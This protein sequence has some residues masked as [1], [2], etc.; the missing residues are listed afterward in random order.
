MQLLPSIN[1]QTQGT[2]VGA[3]TTSL[4]LRGLS[5]NETLVM[6]DGI[7][8]HPTSNTQTDAGLFRG[9]TPTDVDL[10]PAS[11]IDHVEVL[12][13]GASAQYGSDAVA[14][15]I[16]ILLKTSDHGGSIQSDT[17]QYHAGDGLT[18]NLSLD[19]GFKL[20]DRGFIHA[21]L[22]YTYHARTDRTGVD[23]R[24]GVQDSHWLGDP[25]SNRVSLAVNAGYHVTDQIDAYA[26]VT[27]AH[28]DAQDFQIYRLPSIL[29][30]IYPAGFS[31]SLLISENDYAYTGGVRGE[32]FHGWS[33]DLN[34]TY[35][36]DGS[37]INMQHSANTS[38]FAATGS[39]PT[40]F[41]LSS[42]A[43]SQWS[44]NASIKRGFDT[45]LFAAPVNVDLGVEYRRE[46]YAQGAGDYGSYI[47]G[48]S[49]A[50]P[51]VL[52]TSAV[53]VTRN[54]EAVY[55]D[56]STKLTD[57]WQA[58]IAGRYENYSDFGS[59]GT[60]KFSTRYDFTDKIAVRATVNNSI[61]APT[62]PEE[63]HT[64]M[65]V[66]TSGAT[67]ELAPNSA[68]AKVLGATPLKPENS[69]NYTAGLVLRPT[70][71]WSF[72]ADFYQI[73]IDNRIL[74][75]G[76]YSGAQA[77]AAYAAAGR[78][79]PI[80]TSASA[81]S[82]S[83]LTNAANTRTQGLD[84]NTSYRLG[85]GDWG[86]LVLDASVNF[87]QTNIL[88]IGTNAL[89]RTLLN[90]QQIGYLTTDDPQN[91]WIVGGTWNVNRFTVNIHEQGYGRL[92]D[93]MTYQTGPNAFSSSV[94]QTYYMRAASLTNASLTYHATDRL[95]LTIGGDNV[96][97]IYPNKVP[98][99][100]Q[101]YGQ[102]L[103]DRYAQQIPFN[104]G[105]YYISLAYKL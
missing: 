101:Y 62:L 99:L 6:L 85:L 14:G 35:G 50:V 66:T 96:F 1:H 15:V 17:G 97:N 13:D 77:L 40:S 47:L 16:N 41:H 73:E 9:S 95:N 55:A 20:T 52:P 57:K 61:R 8:R 60:G 89:G 10:I 23:S 44:N 80:G 21:G 87:N 104:G 93:Q 72:T 43:A 102:A 31:P 86:N 92:T 4:N 48:G 7:R 45:G 38:L 11:M 24:T 53:S 88:K 76:T 34:S 105:Y 33:W 54:V 90:A 26:L 91:S 94:F 74:D 12:R 70:N 5:P 42:S 27:Y 18:E 75:G 37:N 98:V 100:A 78:T 65:T 19:K 68:G 29:P 83:Y 58:D 36:W 69:L 30:T 49:Q 71:A 32:N 103:Y 59:T 67:G 84:L 25:Q 79:L 22:D 46:Y 3:L 56:I 51:G 63:Y 2:T 81:V 82:A 39:T 28:R 64:S